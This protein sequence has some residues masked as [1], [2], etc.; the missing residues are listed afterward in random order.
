MY[1]SSAILSNE[2][3]KRISPMAFKKHRR[4]P[5]RQD[6][7]RKLSPVRTVAIFTTV[8]TSLP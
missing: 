5:I 8:I 1:C 7:W 4:T 3:Q 6:I 2:D